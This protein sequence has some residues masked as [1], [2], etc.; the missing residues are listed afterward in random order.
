MKSSSKWFYFWVLFLLALVF[1]MLPWVLTP[2][3]SLNMGG[4]DLAEWASLHP[5]VRASSP[6]LLLS[7]ALRLPLALLALVV[8][9][10]GEQAG[11]TWVRAAFVCLLAVAL[12]PSPEFLTQYRD[13][14]NYR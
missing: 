10:S 7:F 1:Y 3:A 13:D 9:F 14:P 12:L 6:P 2:D 5:A 4:Y 11:K 8:A